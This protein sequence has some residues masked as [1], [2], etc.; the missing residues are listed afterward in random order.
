LE[1][2]FFVRSQVIEE[3]WCPICNKWTRYEKATK[4]IMDKIEERALACGHEIT[5][6]F[7]L[8]QI[9][10]ENIAVVRKK[11]RSHVLSIKEFES[12]C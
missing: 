2:L 4:I 12:S 10:G 1:G 8:E 7:G 5:Y 3:E 6:S 9:A 11:F